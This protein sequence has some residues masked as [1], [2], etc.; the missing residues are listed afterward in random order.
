MR[1]KKIFSGKFG[2]GPESW[3][4]IDFCKSACKKNFRGKNFA[5]GRKICNMNMERN[6]TD[7][8]SLHIM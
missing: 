7:M 4:E 5:P 6:S 3:I 1:P 8:K 2:I